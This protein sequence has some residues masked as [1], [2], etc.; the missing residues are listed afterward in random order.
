MCPLQTPLIIK[1]NCIG[2]FVLTQLAQPG[3]GRVMGS[4]SRGLFCLTESGR[5][6]FITTEKLPG[7][8]NILVDSLPEMGRSRWMGSELEHS[9]GALH[10]PK[11]GFKVDLSY[12]ECWQLPERP[13]MI[14]AD[15]KRNEYVKSIAAEILRSGRE[16]SFLSVLK[17]LINPTLK[18]ASPFLSTFEFNEKRQALHEAIQT[19]NPRR[20]ALS[21]N[22]VLGMGSGLT[23]SGDDFVWGFL[24]ALSRWQSVLCPDFDVDKLGYLLLSSARRQTSFLSTSLIECAAHGWADA[25]MLAVLDGIFTGSELASK[26]SERILAYGSSSGVDAFTGM[27]ATLF[28]HP[29]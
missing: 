24:L 18:R 12:A 13:R 4:T 16:S 11:L 27:A 25:N 2:N 21:L 6:L 10:F 22:S 20:A 19:N 17:W 23:P 5:I 9:T 26:I 1:A 7:P 8:L 15:G 29:K 28:I 14:S 3:K